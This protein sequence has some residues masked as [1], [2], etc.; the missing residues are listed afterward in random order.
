MP[1]TDEITYPY[2]EWTHDITGMTESELK[3]LL[4]Q[5]GWPSA[6]E[7]AEMGWPSK[8]EFRIHQWSDP[9]TSYVQ[10][11]ISGGAGSMAK[12][13]QGVYGT[14]IEAAEEVEPGEP[15][16]GEPTPAEK[17]AWEQKY[18]IPYPTL[19][20]PRYQAFGA[21]YPVSD[22]PVYKP[23]PAPYPTLELPI[24]E[25]FPVEYPELPPLY[26]EAEDVISRMLRGE[27]LGLPVEELMAAYTEEERLAMEEY[28]PA[29]R[30]HWAGRKLL[31]SGM[32]RE[33]ERLATRKAAA[34]RGTYRAELEKESV[35]R[36]Q[37]GI[38]TGLQLAMDHVGIGY[39]AE[40]DAWEAMNK[41]YTKV[42]QS[43]IMVGTEHFEASTRA[44]DAAMTEY[45][46][47]FSSEVVATEFG[48]RIEE[49]V[50]NVA[51]DEYQRVYQS[52]YSGGLDEWRADAQGWD[53]AWREFDVVRRLLFDWA[54][55][56][57]GYE[58]EFE[59]QSRSQAFKFE[60][61]RLEH[62]FDKIMFELR[63]AL[64]IELKRMG[65]SSE[66]RRS[67]W[68]TI[69]GIIIGGIG[70]WLKYGGV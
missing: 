47:A 18:G 26:G 13:L 69:G 29:L 35:I 65:L 44:W 14:W 32:E 12:Y 61:L 15:A 34:A 50:F 16:P 6:E 43:E 46:K 36:E 64:E 48:Q 8:H 24:Y 53:A 7:R 4:G 56:K 33:A 25:Q 31:R 54:T 2:F 60:F 59:F 21:E 19:T 70:L 42:Y 23:F 68:E 9:F 11:V 30:E 1:E 58:F 38:V 3:Q 37:E 10:G 63:A 17:E 55:M 45:T 51:R 52:A 67:I 5:E 27:G 49:M 40:R 28:M 66:E 22:L 41:E 57:A 62:E 20:L 39:E